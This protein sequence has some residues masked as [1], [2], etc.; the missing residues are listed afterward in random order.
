MLFIITKK[1]R[2]SGAQERGV[3]IYSCNAALFSYLIVSF[4][5]THGFCGQ[6]GDGLSLLCVVWGLSWRT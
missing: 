3:I 5:I 4:I 2:Q 1:W 6:S